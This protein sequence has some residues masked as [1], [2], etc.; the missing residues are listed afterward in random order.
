M[1]KHILLTLLTFQSAFMQCPAQPT[2]PLLTFNTDMHT[3]KISRI[4]TDAAGKFILTCSTDRTAKLWDGQTGT[5]IRTFRVPFEQEDE[6]V[7]NGCALSPD[8]KTVALGGLTGSKGD[9]CLYIFD[10]ETA[11]MKKKI[12]GL[13]GVVIDIEFSSDGKFMVA[14]LGG[15]NGIRIFETANW[16]LKKSFTD[17][18]AICMDAS[19]DQSGHLATVS[20]DGKIRLYSNEFELLRERETPGGKE[21][22]S[23]SYSPDGKLLAV[24]YNDSYLIQI[25]DG[26]TMKLL[27]E[28]DISG[29]ESLSAKLGVVAFSSDGQ[30]LM[31][32][33]S[34]Q[35]LSGQTRW[36]QIRVW[37][38]Q[39]RGSYLDCSSA[40][41]SIMAIRPMPDHS[42]LYCSSDPSFGR[43]KL[44]GTRVFYT[45]AEI[46][47]YNSS[48][49]SH[50]STNKDGS[51]VG[52]TP[53]GKVPWTF[54]VA[55]RNFLKYLP[56]K[57]DIPVSNNYYNIN[58]TDWQNSISP[59]INSTPTTFLSGHNRSISVD[60]SGRTKRVV[61]GTQSSIYCVSLTGDVLWKTSVQ[62]AAWCVNISDDEKVIIAGLSDGTIR[63]YSMDDGKLLFSLF[64][65]PDK[66]RWV[67]WSPEG[68]FDCSQGAD[69]LIGWHVNQGSDREA[70][71]YPAS[72]FFEKFYTPGLGARILA[73]E[74]KQDAGV[75]I[76]GLKLPPR[77]KIISPG[78]EVR[79]FKPL[80]GMIQSE[81]G[82]IEVT[83]EVTDQ[84]GGIDEILI[85]NN[86]KL[87]QTTDKGFKQGI[88]NDAK[89]LKTFTLTLANG[90]NLIKATAFNTQRTEAMASEMK[91]QYTATQTA[92]PNL[93]LL[94]IGI[95][96]Y[97]NP[98]Y[99][100]NYAIDD[101][102]AVKQEIQSGS[103][104]IF[105]TITT[106]FLTESEVT[107]QRILQEINIIK[108]KAKQEDVFIFYY[109]G[110]GVMSEET[111]P[112]FFIIPYDV[113]QLYGNDGGLMKSGISAGELK[114]FS[115][116]IKSQKQLFILDACQSGG[117]TSTMATRGAV[118][119]KAINQLAR[120]TGTFWLTASGSEQFAGE[121]AQLKHGLF[122]Y[123]LLEGMSGK[124]DV[125]NDKKITVQELS[126]YL[127]DQVPILSK[128]YKGSAQYPNTYV[129]GQD[130]PIIIVK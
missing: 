85:Y 62:V 4:S 107:R 70:L 100:L 12:V 46:N 66:K 39:G 97:K 31:S 57:R 43:I 30:Y 115:T 68:Y 40:K 114:L 58:V 22:C 103:Q 121:F 102:A 21:P 64:L 105:N 13:P 7:L 23:V 118:E 101:A 110:H 94:V 79:G 116:E 33:F 108:S 6:G 55:D 95:N 106:V 119:E 82:T 80:P 75:S 77:V 128:Q 51:V 65:H 67:L 26:S 74:D 38:K 61:F 5:F 73:G 76:A 88:Q 96:Q 111:V 25:F 45:E 48:D 93:Y 9:R 44:D 104:G 17:Y 124:A 27:Y 10:A 19:F 8:G 84:G 16:A 32:G 72:Q 112:Q 35:I 3:S 37:A 98:K 99:V 2:A 56:L 34:Y 83:V 20:L 123:C 1:K 130:F 11:L 52:I 54:S 69:D 87:L 63:W 120:S 109:A 42:F 24:G 86:G 92:K 36:V 81:Q 15:K 127:N 125:Q 113:T 47:K 91:I 59:K 90:E 89:S 53:Y 117:I 78:S 49:K 18:G 50:F 129:Y 29:A 126:A 71:Y 28:P 60:V 14:T 41:N 122:T